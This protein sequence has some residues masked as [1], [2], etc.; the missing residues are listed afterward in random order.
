MTKKATEFTMKIVCLALSAVM[1]F[2]CTAPAYAQAE[3]R[4][5]GARISGDMKIISFGDGWRKIDNKLN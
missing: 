1:C 3:K 2:E 4:G 5:G